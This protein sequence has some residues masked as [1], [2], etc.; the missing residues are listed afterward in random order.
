M[1]MKKIIYTLLC[2][3]LFVACAED[4]GNYDYHDLVEP[5]IT[6]IDEN[7]AVLTYSH[8]QITPDL[9]ENEFP[10]E[11]YAF[12]WKAIANNE[13]E[14]VTVLADT[15]DLDY[16]VKLLPG[17]YKMIYRVKERSTGIFWQVISNLVVSEATSEGW[18]VLCKEGNDN[19][20]RLDMISKVTEQTITDVLKDTGMPDMHNPYKISWMTGNL[21]DPE[22]PFYLTTAE[23]ATRL[24]RNGFQ[25]KEEYKL[26]YEMGSQTGRVPAPQVIN[27]FTIGKLFAD[28]GKVYFA[29]CLVFTGLFGEIGESMPAG[30]VIGTNLV[31]DMIMVPMA[32]IYN[33]EEKEFYGYAPGLRDPVMGNSKP[34][35]KM[36]DMVRL[37]KSLSNGGEIAG[38][39]FEEFPT[40]RDYV[41]MENTTYDP[42]KTGTG[43][44]Y[45]V[46]KQGEKYEVYGMQ[47]G[48]L[49]GGLQ[50]GG[51]AFAIGKAYYGDLSGCT[52]IAQATQFAFSSLNAYMYYAV[53]G[54]VYRVDLQ[55]EGALTAEPQFTLPMGEVVRVL[56]F[57]IHKDR[58]LYLQDYNLVVGSTLGENGKLRIYEG[59]KSG[60]DFSKVK[61][62]VYTGLG[63][64][65]D[66]CYREMLD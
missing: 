48:E 28:N 59:F 53:G 63:N 62:V 42:N 37:I 51:P 65:V 35:H 19:R 11:E 33:T 18:M 3:M 64:I 5:E 43:I 61:P 44:T 25:W 1:K 24:R 23:G 56:K 22:S 31:N 12:E 4:L 36:N 21:V 26:D 17:S 52:N 47:T 30:P 13:T 2:S 20:A 40:G 29:D 66:V 8:L 46:L 45:A 27:P 38:D 34:L 9:G 58:D 55:Q 6:G 50:F 60:G 57:N 10:S 41:W 7:I 14:E 16:E 49:L 39:A 15:R 54:M 32:I